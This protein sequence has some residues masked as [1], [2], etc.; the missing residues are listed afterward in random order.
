MHII[1]RKRLLEFAETHPQVALSLD[2][3]YRV[4]KSANWTNINEV[5]TLR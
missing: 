5:S 2:N 4:A 1:S 3:W